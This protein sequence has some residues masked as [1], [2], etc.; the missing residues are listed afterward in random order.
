MALDDQTLRTDVIKWEHPFNNYRDNNP[1]N[2]YI[3]YG[4]TV[5]YFG[6]EIE[7]RL[8]EAWDTEFEPICMGYCVGIDNADFQAS[9]GTDLEAANKYYDNLLAALRYDPRKETNATQEG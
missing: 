5:G 4:A 2:N 8:E 7:I 1:I 6:D 9:F 3:N